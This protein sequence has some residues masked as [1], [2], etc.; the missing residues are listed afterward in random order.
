VFSIPRPEGAQ[1]TISAV[2]RLHAFLFRGNHITDIVGKDGPAEKR[3]SLKLF[4]SILTG[5][6]QANDRLLLCTPSLLDYF[7]QEKL[8]RMIVEDLPAA[9]IAQLEKSLLANPT[10]VAFAAALLAVIPVEGSGSIPVGTPGAAGQPTAPQRSMEELVNKERTTEQL[11]SPSIMPNVR[12]LVDRG[13]AA[14][15]RFVRTT[16]LRQP[17]RRHVP[18][19]LH[20]STRYT[21]TQPARSPRWQKLQRIAVQVLIIL[22][23]IPRGLARLFGYR[24]RVQS[25]VR[26]LPQ[27]TTTGA[28][29]TV[30]W[31]RS[32]N[33]LQQGLLAAAIVALFILSQTV[34]NATGDRGARLRGAAAEE[35]IVTI[36]DNLS[37]AEAALTYDD[38]AGAK[39]LVDESSQLLD[40]LGNR[41]KTEKERRAALERTLQTV[42]EQTRRVRSPSI[43]TVAEL[44]SLLGQSSPSAVTLAGGTLVVG[45]TEPAG[46]LTVNVASGKATKL[47]A[48]PS[49]VR[50]LLPLSSQLV[51]IGTASSTVEELSLSASRVRP[52]NVTFANVDRT[53]VAGAVF[54][55]RLYLLDTKNNAI[56]RASRTGDSFG[57]LAQWLRDEQADVRDG[58][59]IG[60]DGS[61]YVVTAAGQLLRFTAGE[62]EDIQ[63]E[64]VDPKLSQPTRLWTSEQSSRLYILEPSQQ[65]LLIFNKTNRGLQA[66]YVDGA[67]GQ[68]RSFAVDERGQ[69]IYVLTPDR[70]LRFPLN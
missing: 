7:S 38:V 57:S 26:Q 58:V 9:A 5:H 1:V 18:R 2:G 59:A 33:P 60:V 48:E 53:V 41:S 43:A 10:P 51:L 62:R 70:L 55:S 39:R 46:L 47:E 24:R 64:E 17:P 49:A 32:L 8:K 67:L 30:Q 66:Q 3:N 44:G 50:F 29:R 54:Q 34:I 16:L 14:V 4:S 22:L 36:E 11:L 28:A 21:R 19:D 63:F 13:W 20:A 35:A 23:S 15:S 25:N 37:R 42:R 12:Q 31:I 61:I 65:R 69:I 6:L 56:L 40:R 68:A 45:T 52:L 27:R